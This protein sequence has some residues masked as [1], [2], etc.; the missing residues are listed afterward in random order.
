[1][2]SVFTNRSASSTRSG[3]GAGNAYEPSL[4][5][6]QSTVGGPAATIADLNNAVNQVIN[7]VNQQQF[8][9]ASPAASSTGSWNPNNRHRRSPAASSSG[10]RGRSTAASSAGSRRSFVGNRNNLNNTASSSGIGS[11]SA[12][13]SN[14]VSQHSRNDID[15][16]VNA[17]RYN[18]GNLNNNTASSSGIGSVSAS[19]S[20]LVSQHSRNDINN[21]V[22]AMRYNSN[23]N[24]NN[25]NNNEVARMN[26][27]RRAEAA[28]IRAEVAR[29]NAERRAMN[30]MF[31]P[32]ILF[33]RE[34]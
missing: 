2:S 25:N 11:V 14:L 3:N 12:S 23:N 29:L 27:A 6:S 13:I 24:N 16:V 31:Y 20:N 26:A 18:N 1:M 28:R 17:M 15:N 32:T 4:A 19:I 10:S 22:N 33:T 30:D 5:G 7:A 21:V 8:G 34:D 9:G